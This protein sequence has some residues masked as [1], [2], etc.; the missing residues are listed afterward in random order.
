MKPAELWGDRNPPKTTKKPEPSRRA[1][2]R[3]GL[4]NFLICWCS[5]QE[6]MPPIMGG[7]EFYLWAGMTPFVPLC[8]QHRGA[9]FRVMWPALGRACLKRKKEKTQNNVYP[10]GS[11][12]QSSRHPVHWD[13]S[14]AARAPSAVPRPRVQPRGQLA[15]T[16]TPCQR[17]KH[18]YPAPPP[19]QS[20]RSVPGEQNRRSGVQ[21]GP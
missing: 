10:A 15:G 19:I 7:S 6:E 12:C 17:L 4:L 3:R 5:F 16:G 14:W 9:L 1:E 20:R 8:Q 18:Q 2:F 13:V 11:S 21:A